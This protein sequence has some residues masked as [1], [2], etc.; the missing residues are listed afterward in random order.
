MFIIVILNE[1]RDLL[2]DFAGWGIPFADQASMLSAAKKLFF[3]LLWFTSI[4]LR[5]TPRE[6]HPDKPPC[7]VLHLTS[8]T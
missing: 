8:D 5:K 2:F 4:L 3:L 6:L 7:S 1:V